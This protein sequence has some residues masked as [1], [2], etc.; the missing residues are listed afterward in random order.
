M[1]AGALTRLKI[2]QRLTSDTRIYTAAILQLAQC[3]IP[4]PRPAMGPTGPAGAT[5]PT[6]SVGP[7][8]GGSPGDTGPMGVPGPNGSSG[9]TGPTGAQGSDGSAGTIGSTGTQGSVGPTGAQIAGDA[10]PPGA[11]GAVGTS[12]SLGTLGSRGVPGS[13]GSTG[14]QQGAQGST[15]IRGA[16]GSLGTT[17]TQGVQ[18]PY[19]RSPIGIPGFMGPGAVGTVYGSIRVPLGTTSNFNFSTASVNLPTSFATGFSGTDD[20]S[21]CSI[22]LASTYT[23]TNL[24]QVFMTA[25]IVFGGNYINLQS[26]FGYYVPPPPAPAPVGS[27]ATIALTGVPFTMT[28]SNITTTTF[29]ANGTL[30]GYALYLYIQ[31]LN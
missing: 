13:I 21:S 15:G 3:E 12:G 22:S 17:G 16:L 25:Y 7:A 8:G 28:L 9:S 4:C 5:G 31:I 6:G 20:A 14:T 30:G 26:R 27:G 10:G 24:P 11:T 23:L 29:P 18:G 1:D 19:G 2:L